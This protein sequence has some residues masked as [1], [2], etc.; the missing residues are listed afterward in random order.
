MPARRTFQR[1]ASGASTPICRPAW[2]AVHVTPGSDAATA[3]PDGRTISISCRHCSDTE[4]STRSTLVSTSTSMVRRPGSRSPTTRR[5][6]SSCPSRANS[7]VADEATSEGSSRNT[8]PPLPS[9]TCTIDGSGR[10][11][12]GQPGRVCGCCCCP[13]SNPINPTN[14]INLIN[15]LQPDQPAQPDQPDQPVD[16]NPPLP[17]SLVGQ[18]GHRFPGDA[19]HR[20]DDHLRDPHAAIDG[21]R[22]LPEIDQRDLHLAAVVGVDRAGRVDDGQARAWRPGPTEAA[23][24]PRSPGA[25][26]SQTRTRPAQ[27]FLAR[28]PPAR[29]PPRA[30]PWRPHAPSDRRATAGRR[31]EGEGGTGRDGS[32]VSIR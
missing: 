26:P 32:H 2:N 23:P 22:G 27:S 28:S 19:C 8:C 24:A 16:P 11:T 5:S 15:P 25:A 3:A 21:D 13:T 6:V 31:R 9:D 10:P 7:S 29:S 14:Q 30:G 20:R 1:P 4:N 18:F 12:H 17:R